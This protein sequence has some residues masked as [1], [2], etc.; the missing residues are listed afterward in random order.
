MEQLQK[1]FDRVDPK[2]KPELLE[3]LRGLLNIVKVD[4]AL[5]DQHGSAEHQAPAEKLQR[6]AHAFDQAIPEVQGSPELKVDELWQQLDA[7]MSDV[8]ERSTSEE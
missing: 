4:C 7:Y 6:L 5:H 2:Q 1:V 8:V 3:G